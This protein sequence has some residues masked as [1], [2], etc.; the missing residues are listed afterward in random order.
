MFTC[1]GPQVFSDLMFELLNAICCRLGVSLYE[2]CVYDVFEVGVD[3]RVFDEVGI[4][5][6]DVVA[7]RSGYYF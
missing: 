4:N 5:R 6:C 2:G 7:S 1:F 3:G